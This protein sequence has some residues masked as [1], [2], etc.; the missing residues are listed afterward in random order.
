MKLFSIEPVKELTFYVKGLYHDCGEKDDCTQMNMINFF[1]VATG[2]CVFVKKKLDY[3]SIFKFSI[4][5]H[6][7]SYSIM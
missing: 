7:D 2:L 4:F 5:L 3:E 1:T 6:S